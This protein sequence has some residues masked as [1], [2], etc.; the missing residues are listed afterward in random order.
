MLKRGAFIVAIFLVAGFVIVEFRV[1]ERLLGISPLVFFVLVAAGLVT[2][3][4]FHRHVTS[5]FDLEASLIDRLGPIWGDEREP[6]TLPML[7]AGFHSELKKIEKNFGSQLTRH[8]Q[9]LLRASRRYY[10]LVRAWAF[11]VVLGLLVFFFI[12]E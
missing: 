5:F 12:S 4:P 7:F 9:Q 1:T 2:T 8:E 6:H 3:V 11:V 10:N